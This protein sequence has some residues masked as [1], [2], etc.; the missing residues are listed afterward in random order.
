ME[1]KIAY[2]DASEP[3]CLRY[4]IVTFVD[5]KEFLLAGDALGG[6]FTKKEIEI[7]AKK[8]FGDDVIVNW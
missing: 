4:D 6:E 8:F 7:N 5:G 2:L 3:D 1:I